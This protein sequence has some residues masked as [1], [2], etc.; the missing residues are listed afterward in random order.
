ME[1]WFHKRQDPQILV[2]KKI[3]DPGPAGRLISMISGPATSTP[4]DSSRDELL[5]ELLALVQEI[6]DG[7][8][9]SKTDDLNISL[10]SLPTSSQTET[11]SDEEW[12]MTPPTP[13]LKGGK[14]KNKK[15]MLRY[16]PFMRK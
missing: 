15:S 12:E 13:P 2:P 7:D 6:S 5:R 9:R 1:S 14:K 10:Q 4:M 8:F 11:S 16:V 3:L